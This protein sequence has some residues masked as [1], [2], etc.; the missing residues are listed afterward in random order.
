MTEGH[1]EHMIHLLNANTQDMIKN[2]IQKQSSVVKE[3]TTTVSPPLRLLKQFSNLSGSAYP[4]FEEVLS[5]DE[6]I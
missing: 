1:D 5:P 4:L 2:R 6:V 3:T